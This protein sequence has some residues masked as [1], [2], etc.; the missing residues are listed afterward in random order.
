M[1]GNS[2]ELP[3]LEKGIQLLAQ[4]RGELY[5]KQLSPIL[6][7]NAEKKRIRKWLDRQS[8][9]SIQD[10]VTTLNCK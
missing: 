2:E 6:F 3:E 9:F 4:E 8:E 5:A 10:Y 7:T 1:Q